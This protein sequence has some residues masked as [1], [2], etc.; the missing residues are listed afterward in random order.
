MAIKLSVPTIV[1]EG[2]ADTITEAITTVD[3]DAKVEV[4]VKTKTVT[5]ESEAA[6]ESFKQA[7]VATGHKI[8]E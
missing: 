2:C 8:A 7:I 3:S 6:P 4:D 5:L 1:C